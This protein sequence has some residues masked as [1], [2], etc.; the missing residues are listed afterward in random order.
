MCIRDRPR[1]LPSQI[2][3]PP[4]A[5][6]A[7][8]VVRVNHAPGELA[9]FHTYLVAWPAEEWFKRDA[10]IAARLHL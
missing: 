5:Q 9:T 4:R 1:R 7:F 8:A 6:A 2:L 10:A 3:G